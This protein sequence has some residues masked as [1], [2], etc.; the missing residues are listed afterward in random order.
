[1]AARNF[2]FGKGFTKVYTRMPAKYYE[3][4]FT[5][6]DPSRIN[7]YGDLVLQFKHSDWVAILNGK[8][9]STKLSMLEALE[10]DEAVRTPVPDD[11]GSEIALFDAPP[12]VP[13]ELRSSVS[14][15]VRPPV[16]FEQCGITG[17]DVKVMF[18][19]ESHASG[20]RCYVRCLKHKDEGCVKY[21]FHHH[22]P[23]LRECVV[24]LAAW[25]VDCGD[26]P[27]RAAHRDHEPREDVLEAM[28]QR[29]P[30]IL[31]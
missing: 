15:A 18:D 3:S 4:L 16:V 12:M 17:S 26:P 20:P 21:A 5:M 27:N 14:A 31:F 29:C 23:S 10:D 19:G 2:V 6:A 8:E 25:Q 30:A 11:A 9:P 13:L 22:Y 24:W 28:R 7:A 1:M